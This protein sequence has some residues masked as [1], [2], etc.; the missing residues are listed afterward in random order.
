M[1]KSHRV[2]VRAL[3]LGLTLACMAAACGDDSSS[4]AGGSTGASASSASSAAGAT[5]TTAAP[6][7]GGSLSMAMFSETGGLDPA[8]GGSTDAMGASLDNIASRKPSHGGRRTDIMDKWW[9]GIGGEGD[10]WI[11]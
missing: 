8:V 6:K 2:I 5:T 10:I 11:S 1:A 7:V 9:N 3:A 4:N